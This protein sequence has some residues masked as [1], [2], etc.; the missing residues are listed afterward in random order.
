MKK[1]LRFVLGCSLAIALLSCGGKDEPEVP[2]GEAETDE[3]LVIAKDGESLFSVVYTGSKSTVNGLC[4]YIKSATGVLLPC[5]VSTAPAADYEIV[6]GLSAARPEMAEVMK[7]IGSKSGYSIRVIGKRLYITGS[8][9]NWLQLGIRALVRRIASSGWVKDGNLLI[10][11][12]IS[13]KETTGDPQM[14]ARLISLGCKFTITTSLVMRH[15]PQGDIKVAQGAASDGEYFYFVMRNTADDKAVVYKYDMRGLSL[16]GQSPEFNGGHCNDMAFDAGN[17]RLMVV[18]GQSQG[19]ILTPVDA[20]TLAVSPNVSIPVGSGALTY[21]ASRSSYA[22]SQGGSTFYVADDAFKVTLSATRTDKTGYTAQGMGSDDSYVYFPMS[23][24]SDNILV[25]YD[26][27]GKYVTTLTVPLAI[28]SESMFY[29]AGK[30]YVNFYSSGAALYEITP[31]YYY[32]H[33]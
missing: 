15:A 23:G 32:S 17:R 29:A 21:N 27:E 7:D 26:W 8:D 10:P 4:D 2:A 12:D 1:I 9:S 14:I 3:A 31:V 20:Q 6:A 28:E 30:Y 22:I 33:K 19:K 25:V 5:V 11:K 24:N 16:A 13:I 18:H